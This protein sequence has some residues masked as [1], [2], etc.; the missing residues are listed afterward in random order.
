MPSDLRGMELYL[1]S[2]HELS[3]PF[4]IN[5]VN[6]IIMSKP[7]DEELIQIKDDLDKRIS[8]VLKYSPMMVDTEVYKLILN[9]L[10]GDGLYDKERP[11]ILDIVYRWVSN[12][13]S[14]YYSKY[15]A[16]VIKLIMDNKPP[17]NPEEQLTDK[18][19]YIIED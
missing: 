10:D 11:Y 9:V 13:K 17:R 4:I 19:V 12:E 5:I 18:I 14:R 3:R 2:V 8:S 16:P 1:R 6:D 7:V 15:V